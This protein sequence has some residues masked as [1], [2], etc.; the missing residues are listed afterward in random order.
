MCIFFSEFFGDHDVVIYAIE[1]LSRVRSIPKEFVDQMVAEAIALTDDG[2]VHPP[3]VA[4]ADMPPDTQSFLDLSLRS[5]DYILPLFDGEA[6]ASDDSLSLLRED[7][8]GYPAGTPVLCRTTNRARMYTFFYGYQSQN[9]TTS[10]L[11]QYM[12][13]EDGF[14]ALL[15]KSLHEREDPALGDASASPEPTLAIEWGALALFVAK[16]LASAVI[17]KIGT[18]AFTHALKAI[19]IEI[20]GV[21]GYF[22]K[23]YERFAEIVKEAL[24]REDLEQIKSGT[25]T[26]MDRL[27]QYEQVKEEWILKQTWQKTTELVGRLPRHGPSATPLVLIVLG[28][29][30]AVIQE[31]IKVSDG[32]PE[33]VQRWRKNLSQRAEQFAKW[34]LENHSA[35]LSRRLAKISGITER[36][37]P[38][39][40]W[41]FE[42]SGNGHWEQ[43]VI[44]GY[45]CIDIPGMRTLRENHA[46]YRAR[47][48][49]ETRAELQ[50]VLDTVAEWQKLILPPKALRKGASRALPS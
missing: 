1:R 24:S 35:L 26:V 23:V 12:P 42:D 47:I 27:K 48:E 34:A 50:V 2:P 22:E 32:D 36:K 13:Q 11:K 33:R 44:S 8:R 43:H 7:F 14:R 10:A 16:N 6:L 37:D 46:A 5:A 40:R 9:A 3:L 25:N 38:L 41:Q 18:A 20:D 49:K 4:P 45:Q 21:P 29:E 31:F 15:P 39:I 30:L 19:G 17:S 28:L